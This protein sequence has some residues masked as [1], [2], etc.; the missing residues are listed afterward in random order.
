M[1]GGMAG[2]GPIRLCSWREGRSDQQGMAGLS[3]WLKADS[4]VG[5]QQKS[6]RQRQG[7]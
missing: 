3:R 5:R 6:P 2:L 7:A 1:E 4:G